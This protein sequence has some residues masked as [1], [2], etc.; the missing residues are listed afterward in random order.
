MDFKDRVDFGREDSGKNLAHGLKI[1]NIGLSG[2]MIPEGLTERK[3]FISAK[4]WVP[5]SERWLFLRTNAAGGH[6]TLPI[7]VKVVKAEDASKVAASG[8]E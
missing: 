3:F 1:D 7:R 4:D 8:E 6:A 5:E 2:L